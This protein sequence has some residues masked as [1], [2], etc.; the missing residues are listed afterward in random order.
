MRHLG[1]RPEDSEGASDAMPFYHDGVRHVFYLKTPKGA[2]GAPGPAEECDWA[3][4]IAR[5]G[6]VRNSSGRDSPRSKRHGRR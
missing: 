2:W 4:C 3:S 6:G 5:S 1:F